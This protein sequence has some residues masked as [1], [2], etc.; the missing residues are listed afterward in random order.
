MFT[1]IAFSF[2]L[3]NNCLKKKLVDYGVIG[4]KLGVSRSEI[5]IIQVS[6]SN[7]ILQ[8]KCPLSSPESGLVSCS[9]L[10]M[11]LF[12]N[13]LQFFDRIM[14]IHLRGSKAAMSQ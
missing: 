2:L 7:L 9:G 8:K 1:F 11:G 4:K 3:V 6:H 5:L 13:V 14:G 10:G 12:I